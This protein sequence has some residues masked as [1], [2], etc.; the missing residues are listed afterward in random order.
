MVIWICR[1]MSSRNST[2]RSSVSS[3]SSGKSSVSLGSKGSGSPAPKI[4]APRYMA[5]LTVSFY[6]LSNL[7]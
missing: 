4:A 5:S 7:K 6:I 1:V 2:P 3:V